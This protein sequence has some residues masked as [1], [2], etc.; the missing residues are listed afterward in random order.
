MIKRILFIF[1]T[2]GL[3]QCRTIE[4]GYDTTPEVP[5]VVTP[6]KPMPKLVVGIVVDQMRY[7]YLYRYYNKYGEG[8]F[9]RLLNGG[10]NVK[11]MNFN[12]IP[13]Y[14][15]VG[16]TSIYTGTIPAHHGIISN[17]WYD[18]KLKK[19]I[20]CVDDD[21]YN[22]VGT[23]SKEGKKSPARM[24]TSTLGDQ[25]R[26]TNNQA[27]IIGISLKDRAAI[28]PAGHAANAAYW[29][30]GKD[31]GKWVSSTFY[32]NKMPKWANDF[33][34][35]RSNRANEFLSAPWRTLYSIDTYTESIED[36]NPYEGTFKG[37]DKPVFPHNLPA[38]RKDNKNFDLIK[39]VPFGNTITTDFTIAAIEGENMGMDQNTDL[40]A[41]SYSSTDYVGHKYG[42]AAIETEDTYLRLDKEIERLLTY[43]D[44]K[45]GAGQ[46]TVFLTADHGAVH[47][48]AYLNSLKI[49]SGY[50]KK[51]EF[52]AFVENQCQQQYGSSSIIEN[53]SNYQ[54][55]LNKEEVR[56]KGLNQHEVS[57]FLADVV[58][59]FE[60]IYKAVTAHTLQTNGF[61]DI[62]LQRLQNGY[63]Q[64]FSGD[65]LMV[66]NPAT[67]SY[68]H[69]GTT[70]G[71]GYS[72]DTHVP[73]VFYGF[74]INKGSTENYYNITDIAP[75]I[76]ALLNLEYPNGCT[77]RPIWEAME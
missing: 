41:I 13:T 63:N 19:S 76:S 26:L 36:N 55:F 20:Y 67:I 27:K 10:F 56:Q 43:L 24:L 15:A 51:D 35:S 31:N 61:N 34:N 32:I 33:N 25:L 39:A 14:T 66:P 70:H 42:V 11:D 53:I 40:L 54:I 75:T 30:D 57:Q 1:L 64:K 68:S 49:P 48:P 21:N 37:E 59:E 4:P 7:D 5:M 69:T 58:I 9:K 71:S 22:T 3:F 50:F 62:I 6:A 17:N 52:I 8:G 72:Y 65:V 46:Y 28:L 74:G 60:G 73:G 12:Y 2:L 16:H 44:E 45:V 29:F 77:G 23:D 38:L 47:V 18:K